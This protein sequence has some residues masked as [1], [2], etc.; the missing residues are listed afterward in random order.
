MEA[1]L[2]DVDRLGDVENGT[3]IRLGLDRL[4][5][6]LNPTGAKSPRAL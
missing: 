3:V 4:T 6:Q 2:V 5:E 1:A